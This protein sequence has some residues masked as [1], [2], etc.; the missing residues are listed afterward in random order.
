MTTA[1]LVV[2]V[3]AESM[4]GGRYRAMTI[5]SQ[6]WLVEEVLTG[7]LHDTVEQCEAEIKAHPIYGVGRK[8]VWIVD[9][10]HYTVTPQGYTQRP[11]VKYVQ[12]KDLHKQYRRAQRERHILISQ[13]RLSDEEDTRL[14]NIMYQ[15]SHCEHWNPKQPKTKD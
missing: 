2:D 11:V 14:L 15:T 13:N 12:G 3:V 8:P 5:D 10:D 1:L 6:R 7:Q 4:S 9:L